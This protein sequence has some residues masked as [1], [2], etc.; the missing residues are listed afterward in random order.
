M[1]KSMTAYAEASYSENSIK[2][3]VEIRSYNSKTLDIALYL[4]RA[5]SRYE[6]AIKKLIAAKLSRGRVEIRV[7]VED[8]SEDA[9]QFE[10]DLIRAKAYCTALLHL[11]EGLIKEFSNSQLSDK[12]SAIFVDSAIT[13]DE[14]LNAKDMIK[15]VENGQD[16]DTAILDTISKAV[17]SA[18]ESLEAMRSDEGK[19]LA[20]D[21]LERINY[22]EELLLK[23][24]DEAAL[25]P[26]IYRDRLME[27]V[28][29][30]MN[31]NLPNSEN[32]ILENLI[33]PVRV[34]QEAAFLADKS[35]I[36][37]EIVRVKSHIKLFRD[38]VSSLEAG[39]R[40]LNFLVQEFNREFNT[41]G[42]KSGRAEL[43]HIVVE[44][45]SELEKI[46]EQI[47]NIE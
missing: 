42:S 34:A 1:I 39:G 3:D 18:L 21:L 5:F 8:Q 45:K 33:D 29:T 15:P 36:S 44:L 31:I 14:I 4:S 20:K 41:M 26:Q 16:N 17:N 10:V 40:K 30:L 22:I 6:D 43:S 23:V 7:F 27:R 25:M 28:T 47:Q 13:V 19:N 11:K 12:K 32:K 37:E 46:R 24:Q 38:I 35:D 2:C 9:V